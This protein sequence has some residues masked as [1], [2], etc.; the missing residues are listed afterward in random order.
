MRGSEEI[1]QNSLATVYSG[2]NMSDQAKDA[3]E[4]G[5]SSGDEEPEKEKSM[6]ICEMCSKTEAKYT[7]P[8][9]FK[10]TCSLECVREHKRQF[11]C[12]GKRDV[13]EYKNLSEFRDADLQSDFHFLMDTERIADNAHREGYKE[14]LYVKNKTPQHLQQIARYARR[15]GVNMVIMPISFKRRKE[16]TSCFCHDRKLMLWKL[17]LVFHLDEPLTVSEDRVPD[18]T[19]LR[20]ILSKYFNNSSTQEASVRC[21]LQSFQSMDLNDLSLLLK[22]EPSK[23]SPPRVSSPPQ[24]SLPLPTFSILAASPSSST[25]SASHTSSSSLLCLSHLLRLAGQRRQ[26]LRAI[27][28]LDH[29]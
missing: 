24:L 18:S 22:V 7:C 12:S 29:R 9:C 25:S 1:F 16:N 11:S 8:A 5:Q 28:G 27:D 3:S 15:Q 14:K 4:H 2:T 23:V 26:V 17:E 21:K 6:I 19:S 10:K 13:A 20:E